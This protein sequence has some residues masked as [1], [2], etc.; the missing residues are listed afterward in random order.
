MH[1][2]KSYV[3]ERYAELL[4]HT[5]TKAVFFVTKPVGNHFFISGCARIFSCLQGW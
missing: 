4:Q 5:I 1:C 2:R 3:A